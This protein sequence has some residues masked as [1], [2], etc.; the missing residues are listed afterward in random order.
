QSTL[1]LPAIT[2]T[3]ATS[4]QIVVSNALGLAVSVL[5]PVTVLDGAPF[6]IQQPVETNFAYLGTKFSLTSVVGGSGPLHFKWL[7][8]GQELPGPASDTLTFPRV[9]VTNSGAYTL[10]VSNSFGSVTSSVANLTILSVVAW[11]AFDIFYNETNVPA[12]LTNP[13]AISAGP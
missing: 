11:G 1:S 12:S 10:V 5:A 9:Q 6:F 7:F 4:Y 8:N 2:S 3:D 13:I